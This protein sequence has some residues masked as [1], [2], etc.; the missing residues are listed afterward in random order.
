M[1]DLLV[2]RPDYVRV[3]PTPV[4]DR[5]AGEIVYLASNLFLGGDAEVD[6]IACAIRKVCRRYAGGAAPGPQST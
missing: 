2:R 1:K 3:L 5:A 6:D 4:A